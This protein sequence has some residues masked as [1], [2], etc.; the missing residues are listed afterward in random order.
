M[1]KL[2]L[3]TL[4]GLICIAVS[5]TGN[6]K[7]QKSLHG[8]YFYKN[9]EFID[10]FLTQEIPWGLV[11]ESFE[12]STGIE[13]PFGSPRIA[14]SSAKIKYYAIPQTTVGAHQHSVVRL[15]EFSFQKIDYL[16]RIEV[17]KPK[18]LITYGSGVAK[19]LRIVGFSVAKAHPR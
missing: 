2:N 11:Y 15:V 17:S 13:I 9:I 12:D 4:F 3:A 6:L 7:A 1:K 19:V 5:W 8:L 14:Y 16:L 10:T 18:K